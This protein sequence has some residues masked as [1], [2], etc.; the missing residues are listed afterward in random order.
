M[1]LR[2][3]GASVRVIRPSLL[4]LLFATA[5]SA[6]QAQDTR[7][8]DGSGFVDL[9]AG[10]AQPAASAPVTQDGFV[11]LTDGK[12]LPGSADQAPDRITLGN[13]TIVGSYDPNQPLSVDLTATPDD[14]IVI[15]APKPKAPAL[16]PAGPDPDDPFEQTN[17]SAFASH[18]ALQRN[19]VVPV[20][21]AYTDTVPEVVRGSLHNL[22][23][24]LEFPAIFI[25]DSL[26][27]S[28]GRAISTMARFVVNSTVGIGGLL[29]PATGFGLP[30]RDNDFGATLANYG[31]GDYPYLMVPV[32]GPTNPRDLTGKV[33][34]IFLNPV[35]YIAVPGGI[36]TDAAEN[37]V[38]ELDRRAENYQELQRIESTDKDPYVTVRKLSR[39]R[40]N[41]E[42]GSGQTTE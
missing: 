27:L 19:V 39:E 11:D 25:N 1:A 30:F 10:R 29:D 31:V 5:A 20:E 7:A 14:H 15:E 36:L 28:A 38:R 16:A 41:A 12:P 6:A 24:N 35:H 4:V 40:R 42:I 18:M 26:Q 22:L 9:S 17:R 13:L 23:I 37:G 21:D 33:V 8:P 34:D 32:I 2:E 3:T